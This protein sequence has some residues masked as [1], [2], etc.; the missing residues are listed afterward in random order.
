MYQ[1]E[2]ADIGSRLFTGVY[3]GGNAV[4]GPFPRHLELSHVDV[5]MKM[6]RQL[7]PWMKT[8]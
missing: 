7:K 8:M 5:R 4:D 2:T 3:H 6:N 1:E